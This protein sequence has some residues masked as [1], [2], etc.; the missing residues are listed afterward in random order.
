MPKA[1]RSNT[2]ERGG[3]M[4]CD[5]MR[6]IMYGMVNISGLTPA[7]LLTL[8]SYKLLRNGGVHSHGSWRLRLSGRGG[9]NGG[10][11]RSS[12][13]RSCRAVAIPTTLSLPLG[14]RLFF[15]PPL[16]LFAFFIFWSRGFDSSISGWCAGVGDRDFILSFNISSGLL[17]FFA[18][19]RHV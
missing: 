13:R 19:V 8:L 3:C 14:C 9:G 10:R 5:T 17:G 7:C 16:H 6:Y 2:R 1:H 4:G 12:D 15:I 11:R 18:Y